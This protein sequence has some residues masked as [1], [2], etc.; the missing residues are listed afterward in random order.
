M[1]KI[2]KLAYRR[3]ITAPGSSSGGRI[4]IPNEVL[5]A[6]KARCG[7]S[8]EMVVRGNEIVITKSEV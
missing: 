8:V 4:S 5:F 6:L 3:K 1:I 2:E 7:D